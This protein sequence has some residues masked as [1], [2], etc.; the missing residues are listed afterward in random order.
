[1]LNHYIALVKL[2][3]KLGL[4]A[5]QGGLLERPAFWERQ[6]RPWIKE[7]F[8]ELQKISDLAHPD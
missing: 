8:Q 4:P 2:E 5:F 7:G 1:L 3:D 6:L